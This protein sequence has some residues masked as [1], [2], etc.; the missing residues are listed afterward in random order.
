MKTLEGL[1]KRL[2]R[3]LPE[4]EALD[5]LQMFCEA[6]LDSRIQEICDT[7]VTNPGHPDIAWLLPVRDAQHCTEGSIAVF[8]FPRMSKPYAEYAPHHPSA[9]PFLFHPWRETD[10]FYVL[11]VKTNSCY[12]VNRWEVRSHNIASD[13]QFE[14]RAVVDIDQSQGFWLMRSP[15]DTLTREGFA[16][17]IRKQASQINDLQNTLE[18]KNRE[19]DALGYVW[20]TGN[21]GG[22]QYRWNRG[23]QMHEA[24]LRAG[25][26]SM[27]RM[28]SRG[29]AE[30]RELWSKHC[31]SKK[32]LWRS[33]C[34]H[35]GCIWIAAK[36]ELKSRK[37]KRV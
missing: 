19:L 22:G 3:E 27:S 36:A 26:L 14:Y 10:H 32:G 16:S 30:T 18:I 1:F 20:C 7:Q 12:G 6:A 25:I 8:R 24:T 23:K 9:T 28:V 37:R 21:C 5:E 29:S 15:V 33:V 11:A 13:S 34:Y 31:K 2:R 35:L 4:S 17:R